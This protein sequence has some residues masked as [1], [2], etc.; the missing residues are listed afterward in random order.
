MVKVVHHVVEFWIFG[1]TNGVQ[2]PDND[3]IL[4]LECTVPLFSTAFKLELLWCLNAVLAVNNHEFVVLDLIPIFW[5]CPKEVS[6]HIHR[7]EADLLALIDVPH[8]K[9]LYL[10]ALHNFH[11]HFPND[12]LVFCNHALRNVHLKGLH[13]KHK[14]WSTSVPEL[15]MDSCKLL[16]VKNFFSITLTLVVDM[17]HSGPGASSASWSLPTLPR[18]LLLFSFNLTPHLWTCTTRWMSSTPS[19]ACLSSTSRCRNTWCSHG[20]DCSE[21]CYWCALSQSS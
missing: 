15:F 9:K 21:R 5:L 18:W 8:L 3:C 14:R 1:E 19:I 12:V 4:L 7:D 6:L 17:C 16:I 13:P 11:F 20:W 10:Y 2:I